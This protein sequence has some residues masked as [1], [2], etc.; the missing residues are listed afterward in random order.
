MSL[1]GQNTLDMNQIHQLIAQCS[2]MNIINAYELSEENRNRVENIKRPW[3][4]VEVF[5]ETCL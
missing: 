3:L 5:G 1:R 4:I 2:F